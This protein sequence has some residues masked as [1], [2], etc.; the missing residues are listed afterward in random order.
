VS[1]D[2][3]PAEFYDFL[4]LSW[5][6]VADNVEFHFGAFSAGLILAEKSSL[7]GSRFVYFSCDEPDVATARSSSNRPVF[8]QRLCSS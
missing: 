4:S 1:G 8:E 7:F 6:P 2:R 5:N 3:V